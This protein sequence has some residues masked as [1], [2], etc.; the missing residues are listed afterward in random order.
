MQSFFGLLILLIVSIPPVQAVENGRWKLT[1]T[2]F[3]KIEFGTEKL[4]GGLNIHWQTELEFKID[5]NRFIQG[6]GVARLLDDITTF[7]RPA[8]M[9]NCELVNG[10]F[11]SRTGMSFSMPHLR[12]KA[13]PL[14]GKVMHDSVQLKPFLEYPGNYYA[15]L[16]QCETTNELGSFWVERSPRVARE[17][18]KRQNVMTKFEQGAYQANIKEVISISPGPQIEI[19]LIDG[20]SFSLS[21]QYGLRK[22]EYSLIRTGEK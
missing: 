8:E 1:I 22:L 3:D 19:P 15:V 13:F 9:F 14:A 10:T 7:S 21:E 20:L 2:G 17:L 12:Y 6:T 18:S 16:Y 4:A 5:D 11:A